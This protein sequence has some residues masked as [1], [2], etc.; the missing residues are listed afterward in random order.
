MAS[1]LGRIDLCYFP[2]VYGPPVFW[3]IEEGISISPF[4][5]CRIDSLVIF[6]SSA[7]FVE[8]YSAIR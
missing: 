2:V 3:V 7:V 6:N 8:A 4:L 5:I 1:K